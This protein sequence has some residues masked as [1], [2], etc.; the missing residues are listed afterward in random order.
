MVNNIEDLWKSFFLEVK[1]R[2]RGLVRVKKKF[3]VVSAGSTVPLHHILTVDTH[4]VYMSCHSEVYV[5]TLSATVRTVC[6]YVLVS[7]CLS[8]QITQEQVEGFMVTVARFSEKFKSEG[9]GTV[10]TDLD[11]GM[12]CVQVHAQLSVCTIQCFLY[13]RVAVYLA[14]KF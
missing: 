3:T 8:V 11:R 10:G 9:P 7:V 2:D 5:R 6:T 14:G 1:Q 4:D 12:G 13:S